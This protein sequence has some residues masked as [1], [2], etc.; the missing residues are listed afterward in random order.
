MIAGDCKADGEENPG[1][2]CQVCNAAA[3]PA[4][5]SNAADGK[6]CS[7][8]KTAT[9]SDQCTTGI[10][11]GTAYTCDDGL[12]CT[13]D[14]HNGS[15]PAP[16]GCDIELMSGYC[17]IGGACQADGTA[18]PTNACEVCDTST[19]TAAWTPVTMNCSG[20]GHCA[21]V[22]G[23]PVC[24]CDA[25]YIS[26][27]DECVDAT[28]GTGK[29]GDKIV[30]S[31]EE[32]SVPQTTPSSHLAVGETAL[33]V[34]NAIGFAEDDHILIITL[35]GS[36]ATGEFEIR[37]IQNVAG[38]TLNLYNGLEHSF[39]LPDF[40]VVQKVPEYNN[41]SVE[42]QG[43][44]TAPAWDGVNGGGVLAFMVRGTLTVKGHIDMSGRGYR[45]GMAVANNCDPTAYGEDGGGTIEGPKT[46][47]TSENNGGGGGG[48]ENGCM[49]SSGG[50]GAHLTAGG[51]GTCYTPEPQNCWTP[52]AGGQ[53]YAPAVYDG[54]IFLG[55]GG[56]GGGNRIS[57]VGN[58]GAG[59]GIIWIRAATVAPILGD[60]V[61]SGANGGTSNLDTVDGG[62]GGGAG[63]TLFLLSPST[64]SSSAVDVSGGSGGGP[65]LGGDGG[66]GV[67]RKL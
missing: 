60:F 4:G 34:F 43:T 48:I 30:T 65:L 32:V 18:N 8:G 45:G 10:C 63:G 6:T 64:I 11:A 51:E 15:G 1:D 62:G 41:V 61:A 58:G 37:R 50:G 52:G 17:N 56:G 36:V 67:L 13:T 2:V 21:D 54:R 31:T 44:L 27:G 59:G 46:D 53:P 57:Q 3:N 20:H 49:G 25:G 9:H 40:V 24:E 39:A 7:D 38:N 35:Q 23:S 12:S 55:G 29:D 28:F 14:T 42:P 22:G 26:M 19:S 66:D 33:P 47:D 5:W 16:G